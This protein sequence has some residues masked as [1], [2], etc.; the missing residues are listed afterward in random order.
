MA[1]SI[2]Y[3]DAAGTATS[4]GVFIPISDL[5]G[6]QVAELAGAEP[7]GTKES[8]T[9]LSLFTAITSSITNTVLGLSL[10]KAVP[11]GGGAEDLVN[12][13]FTMTWQKL[14]NLN[15]DTIQNIDTPIDGANAGVGSFGILQAFPNAVKVAAAAAVAG[16]GVVI[17]TAGLTNYTSLSH[18]SLNVGNDNRDWF[19]ALFDAIATDSTLRGATDV[20]AVITRNRGNVGSLTIP[21]AFY[22][23]TDP[24]S[25][26]LA[27]ELPQLGLIS[28]ASTLTVQLKL[29]QLTQAFEVNSVTA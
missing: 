17:N 1:L 15:A 28:R 10:L 18:A 16:A 27:S 11:V 22:A 21:A 8:K 12:Q 23:D 9:V 2:E 5:P 20:S 29:N 7:V 6:V 13:S 14:V 19:A 4:D 3:F 26:V 24:T 25:N